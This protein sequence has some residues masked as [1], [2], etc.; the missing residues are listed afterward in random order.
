[1]PKDGAGSD[2]DG[3]GS[4]V[5]EDGAGSEDEGGDS[6]PEGDGDVSDDDG[7]DSDVN[8]VPGLGLD[9]GGVGAGDSDEGDGVSEEGIGVST[10]SGRKVV[11]RPSTIAETRPSG[12]WPR[13]RTSLPNPMKGNG[14][15]SNV[16]KANGFTY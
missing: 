3:V 15:Q 16:T 1:M 13:I 6:V 5:L 2:D 10:W 9:G 8:E 12:D 4:G 11:V 14:R 7:T